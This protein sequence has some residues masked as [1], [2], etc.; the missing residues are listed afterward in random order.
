MNLHELGRRL[1]GFDLMTEVKDVIVETGEELADFNRKQLDSGIRSTGS[2]IKPAYAPLTILLKDQKGQPTD[3]VTL[4]DTGD[5][6]QGIT[7]DVNS[8]TFDLTSTDDKTEDL[9]KKYGNRIFGLTN[10]SRGEYVAFSFF[11]ALKDRIT[12]RLGFKFG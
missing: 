12:N 2:E 4:K 1:D 10:E 9:V 11:P 5:F 3:R 6:Y 8:E 7:V